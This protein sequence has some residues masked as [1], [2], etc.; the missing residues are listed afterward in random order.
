M[1]N[2]VCAFTEFDGYKYWSTKSQV[3]ESD[4][5]VIDPD[6][7]DYL[8]KTY[9]GDSKI[10]VVEL[11]AQKKVRRARMRKRG[12]SWLKVRKRL[13]H[14]K[15]AF[16]FVDSDIVINANNDNPNKV[17]KDVVDSVQMFLE[18]EECLNGKA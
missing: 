14:D 1:K 18:L 15:K 12:D 7:I 9:A 5:Y 8:K 16:G 6:G 4:V 3:G 11:L 10:V 13:T 2:E 17:T